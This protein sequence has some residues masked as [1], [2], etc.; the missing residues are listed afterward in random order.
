MGH[1][2]SVCGDFS[3]VC[4]HVNISVLLPHI[5]VAKSTTTKS[6]EH[7]AGSSGKLQ[8]A[9]ILCDV[10]V[11]YRTIPGGSRI[12]LPIFDF[13][14]NLL[15]PTKPVVCDHASIW[16]VSR[17]PSAISSYQQPRHAPR[18]TPVAIRRPWW[19]LMAHMDSLIQIHLHRDY[20]HDTEID[21][22]SPF[23]WP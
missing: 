16:C 5:I 3:K 23:P 7:T 17:P 12:S 21:L 11:T 20:I 19:P 15:N 6:E 1:R 10:H 8:G 2:Q 9:A 4:G 22:L 18:R 13:P 14:S